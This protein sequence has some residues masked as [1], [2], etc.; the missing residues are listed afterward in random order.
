MKIIDLNAARIYD[1]L[2]KSIHHRMPELLDEIKWK[3]P[4]SIPDAVQKTHLF[5]HLK[6][7]PGGFLTADLPIF[8]EF[9]SAPANHTGKTLRFIASI[10]ESHDRVCT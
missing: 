8:N 10:P 7:F 3:R 9:L 2:N 5:L 6:R 1:R 4:S